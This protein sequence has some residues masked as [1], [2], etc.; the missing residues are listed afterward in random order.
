ME[1]K[2]RLV[3][4]TIFIV[5]DVLIGLYMAFKILENLLFSN[6]EYKIPITL[7]SLLLSSIWFFFAYKLWKYD[8]RGYK[9]PIFLLFFP[10]LFVI[11]IYL[12]SFDSR[13]L[14]FDN[15]IPILLFLS[16]IIYFNAPKATCH[17]S[18]HTNS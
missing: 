7:I 1:K 11:L 3:G 14:R 15:L 9:F 16:H 17:Y 5:I 2:R 13:I 10:T 8:A 6:V 12:P 4:I 18:L